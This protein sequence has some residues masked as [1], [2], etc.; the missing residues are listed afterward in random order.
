[1]SLAKSIQQ[2]QRNTFEQ[3]NQHQSKQA[4]WLPTG[5]KIQNITDSREL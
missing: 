4:D 5:E 3:T 2:Y 1:M